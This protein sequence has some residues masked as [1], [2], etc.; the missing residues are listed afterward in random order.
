[1]GILDP[2]GQRE[3]FLGLSLYK[4]RFLPKGTSTRVATK[5]IKYHQ[6]TVGTSHVPPAVLLTPGQWVYLIWLISAILAHMYSL[7][8]EPLL[9]QKTMLKQL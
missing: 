1:M 4:H 6:Y 9:G 3:L 5:L 7:E 2:V 8:D